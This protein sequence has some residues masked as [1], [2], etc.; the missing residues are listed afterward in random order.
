VAGTVLPRKGPALVEVLGREIEMALGEHLLLVLPEDLPVVIGRLGSF[1]GELGVSIDDLVVGRA[2][3]AP[4]GLLGLALG[5]RLDE[6][7]IAR[8]R[9]LPGVRRAWSVE[10][11]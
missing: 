2:G 1:F 11:A 5:R 4:T 9:S 3:S 6:E 7:E 8:L 10:L